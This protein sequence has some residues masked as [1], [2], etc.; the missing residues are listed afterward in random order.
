[1]AD[2]CLQHALDVAHAVDAAE[3]RHVRFVQHAGRQAAAV[4]LAHVGRV[5]GNQIELTLHAVEI[6][7]VHE[8][9]AV[10]HAVPRGVALGDS[11]RLR[12]HVGGHH[13]AFSGF[14]RQGHGDVAAAGADV[15]DAGVELA[16]ESGSA[17]S[18][19]ISVSGRG[20]STAGVTSNSRP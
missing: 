7:R 2:G 18:T 1:M 16:H 11:Q 19:M 9:D 10:E 3:Q 15:G 8:L 20:M 4:D 17:A 12:R 5:G 14:V 13:S 6:G